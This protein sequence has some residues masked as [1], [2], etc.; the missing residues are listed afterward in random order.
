MAKKAF[1]IIEL[2]IVISVIAILVAMAI[3]RF[4]GIQEE[5][6]VSRAKGD[7]RTL[8]IAVESYRMHESGLPGSL[9]A[10]I[11]STT[12]PNMVGS[13]LPKDP[14]KSGSDYGYGMSPGKLYYVIWSAGPSGNDTAGVTDSGD[15]TLSSTDTIY[16]SDGKI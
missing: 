1:T 16:A 8:L 13:S 7:V 3:P 12:K 4:R 11:A 10:L 2:L 5:G 9:S 15:V 14:F 6:N